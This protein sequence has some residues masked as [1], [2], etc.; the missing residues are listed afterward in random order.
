[1]LDWLDGPL[2][3]RFRTMAGQEPVQDQST[4]S[5]IVNY[6]G[7]PT[8]G[9]ATQAAQSPGILGA[10][11]AKGAAP[12]LAAGAAGAAPAAGTAAASAMAGP[13]A[14]IPMVLSAMA[15]Q[16]QASEEQQA[17]MKKANAAATD[18]RLRYAMQN[19]WGQ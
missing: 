17:A 1:M 13:L 10:M 12:G 4:I 3:N 6:F 14:A 19:G 15:S 9:P 11:A 8:V 5:R 7:Q 2:A 16:G 18:D